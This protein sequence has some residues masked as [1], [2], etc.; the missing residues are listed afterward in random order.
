MLTYNFS[1]IGSD[2]LYEYLYNC[3]NN[4]I[5]LGYIRP[6]EMLPSIRTFAKNLGF[7]FITVE[8]AYAQLVAEGYLYSMP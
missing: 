3:I 7:S 8:N 6:G 1:N 4:V 2:S 5:F